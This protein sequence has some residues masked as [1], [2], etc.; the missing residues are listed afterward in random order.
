MNLFPL[1]MFSL[2]ATHGCCF[3]M[4]AERYLR[5]WPWATSQQK[6]KRPTQRER[7]EW[8]ARKKKWW[9]VEMARDTYQMVRN[10]QNALYF[11]QNSSRENERRKKQ[12][13]MTTMR[14][15]K[16]FSLILPYT[17]AHTEPNPE[18]HSSQA[19]T[20]SSDSSLDKEEQEMPE[21]KKSEERMT[22]THHFICMFTGSFF[23][24]WLNSKNTIRLIM[25]LFSPGSFSSEL[26]RLRMLDYEHKFQL[27][28]SLVQESLRWIT[29]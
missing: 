7:E 8:R 29:W 21:K 4:R 14:F 26:S 6:A 16:E 23:S 1:F 10:R 12:P 13:A 22:S 19:H 3:S 18:K 24:T 9:S 17:W 28:D 20:I 2:A 5:L 27:D 11:L 15:D 25:M